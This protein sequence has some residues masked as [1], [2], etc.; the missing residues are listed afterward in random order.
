MGDSKVTLDQFFRFNAEGI[1]QE[2][3]SSIESVETLSSLKKKITAEA[4]Q[5]RWSIALGDIMKK[6]KELLDIDVGEIIVGVWKKRDELKKYAD[7]SKYPP[8]ETYLITLLEH[9]VTSKHRPGIEVLI[10]GTKVKTIW[11]D[12]EFALTLESAVLEI[13]GG[14]IIG[15]STG[16]CKG[17]G[18]IRC[19]GVAL[20]Q[21]QTQ[22][23]HL[24]GSLTFDPGIPIDSALP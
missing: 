13:D 22:P 4:K 12:I 23:F 18:A 9:T 11:F 2:G 20:V 21:K 8:G 24:P 14:S 5:I 6:V 7:T 15:V 17:M 10:N 3:L 19:E 1:S 16:K